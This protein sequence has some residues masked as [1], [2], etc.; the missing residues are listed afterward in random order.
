M[1]TIHICQPTALALP[2]ARQA[3]DAVAAK[4]AREYD[5]N[6]HW[7]A[8]ELHFTRSGVDGRIRLAAQQVE[9]HAS[10]GF[11]FSMMRDAIETRVR[12]MLEEKLA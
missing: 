8:D 9:L 10:L 4:L 7:Q 11:P 1:S 12:Q 3:V 5:F 2:E 6:C